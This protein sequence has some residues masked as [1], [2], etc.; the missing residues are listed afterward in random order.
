MRVE[1]SFEVTA[2]C[3]VDRKP[4]VYSCVVRAS[5]VI[6]VEDILAAVKTVTSGPPL[7]Q[8][9]LTR[10]LHRALAAEV[11]TTGWHSGIRT[12]VVCGG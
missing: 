1:H 6:P 2:T 3:P 11:E 9:D 7:F 4:D 12:R 8:E 10:E 5:R